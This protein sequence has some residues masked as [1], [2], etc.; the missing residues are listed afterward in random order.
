MPSLLSATEGIDK[1]TIFENSSQRYMCRFPEFP[2]TRVRNTS[3]GQKLAQVNLGVESL[4]VSFIV[5]AVDFFSISPPSTWSN[6]TTLVV[7]SPLLAPATHDSETTKLLQA[8]ASAAHHMP[9]LKTMEI[10]NGLE[11]LAA[12]FRYEFAKN[13]REPSVIT[14]RA[15]WP[16]VLQTEVIEAWKE[17][18]RS[19]EHPTEGM[20]VVY[21]SV[22]PKEIR[23]HADAIVSLMLPV[24][25]IRPV[26]LR[27]IQREQSFFDSLAA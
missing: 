24:I 11:G 17:V 7:T 22:N 13:D 25:V 23:S 15:T 16:L 19:Q 27:Q 3:L 12:L 1:F 21:E 18:V 4:S 20:K 14:W 9:K 2:L 6:L 5:D 26:S 10:W 8:A